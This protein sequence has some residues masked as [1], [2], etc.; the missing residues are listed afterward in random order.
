L[1][2]DP[3]NI[4]LAGEGGQGVQLIG[5]ILAYAAEKQKK[6][7]S[8]IPNFGVEQRGG[9]SLA[10]VKI[11]KAPIPY[12]KFRYADILVVLSDRAIK[13][14]QNYIDDET[15]YL[16]DD[17]L[18]HNANIPV[19]DREHKK[20]PLKHSTREMIKKLIN[21]PAN[22]IAQ[23][24]LDPRTFNFIILGALLG[25]IGTIA[26]EKVE[27]V[28]DE[29]LAEKLKKQREIYELDLAALHTG[30]KLILENA[31]ILEEKHEAKDL[32]FSRNFEGPTAKITHYPVV[33]KSCGMCQAKCPVKAISMTTRDLAAYGGPVPEWEMFKCIAC[34]QCEH[35][36]PDSA[37][38]VQVKEK[39]KR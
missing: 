39:G 28:V 23:K 13:R 8:Y 7:A 26:E 9:V 22:K 33:C 29:Q 3:T 6:F 27:D 17:S 37:I 21:I 32:K 15:I 10:Y 1:K 38:N 31:K 34:E 12:P 5:Q 19:I 30:I 25:I 20:G 14:T 36:C 35:I 24:D 2:A 16:Y 18:V 11:S 4:L